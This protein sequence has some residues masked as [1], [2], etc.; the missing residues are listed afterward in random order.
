MAPENYT[1]C[2]TIAL[3]KDGQGAVRPIGIGEVLQ[4]VS[5]KTVSKLLET[6]VCEAVGGRKTCS[7]QE[8]GNEAAIQ[9]A[10][11]IYGLASTECLLQTDA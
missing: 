3:D 6:N 10:T 1:A 8:S 4:T 7:G 5:D 2:G 9:A 11:K